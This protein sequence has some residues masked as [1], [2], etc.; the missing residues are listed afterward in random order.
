[1]KKVVIGI[2]LIVVIIIVTFFTWYSKNLQILKNIKNFNSEYEEFLNKKITGVDL[3]TII[4]KALENNNS[5]EIEKNS[6][7][8]YKNDGKNSI[9]IM[10]KP[11]KERKILSNGSF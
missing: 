9:Q 6:D 1:M 5:Y 2:L 8:S 3:T 7:G 10:I 11:T 4:N